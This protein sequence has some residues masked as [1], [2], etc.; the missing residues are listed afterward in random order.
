MAD[1]TEYSA[2]T[3]YHK[4][5]LPATN[6]WRIENGKEPIAVPKSD[7]NYYKYF[8]PAMEAQAKAG[9]ARKLWLASLPPEPQR[10]PIVVEPEV[11]MVLATQK[12]LKREPVK[13]A[14]KDTGTSSLF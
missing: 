7:K 9:R 11:E 3:D 8:T 10:P 5:N 1:F 13:R 4:G 14:K 12:I 2:L 6:Y